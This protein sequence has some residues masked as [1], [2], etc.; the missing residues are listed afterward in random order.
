MS[1]SPRIGISWRLESY[2]Q[3]NGLG[4]DFMD[5]FGGD[6]MSLSEERF[7]A[8]AE[9]AAEGTMP[10]CN[11]CLYC[12]PEIKL[13]GAG[14]DLNTVSDYGRRAAA[15]AKRLGMGGIGIGSGASRTIPEGYSFEK[16]ENELLNSLRATADIGAQQGLA[17]MLEPLNSFCC[18]HLLYTHE[19]AEFVRR[20]ERENMS[21]VFD[22]HHSALMGEKLTDLREFVPMMRSVQF[23]E[24]DWEKGNKLF[25]RRENLDTYLIWLAT[26]LDMGYEGDF[27]VEPVLALDFPEEIKRT[28]D[29]VEEIK[30]RLR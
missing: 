13:L 25:L 21:M 12:P 26:L 19:V 1:K 29:V 7:A 9:A 30:H 3:L 18:N 16:A 2:A 20:T 24:I 17:L 22:L 4:F 28:R 14:F 15:R 10:C 27:C 8:L 23:N 5:V 11:I 6:M